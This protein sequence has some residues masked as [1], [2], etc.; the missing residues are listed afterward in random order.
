M[1]C[2]V[3]SGA[4]RVA[5]EAASRRLRLEPGIDHSKPGLVGVVLAGGSINAAVSMEG[6]DK[7]GIV[8]RVLGY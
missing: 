8:G 6:N 2:E 3:A 7:G 5:T 1:S 4:S